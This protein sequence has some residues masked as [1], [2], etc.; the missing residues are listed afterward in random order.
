MSSANSMNCAGDRMPCSGWSQRT[1]ASAPTMRWSASRDQR[2]EVDLDL[3]ALHGVVERGVEV[4]PADG[5]AAHPV[6]V[7]ER[8]LAAPA[9]LLGPVHGHVRI[10]QEVVT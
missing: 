4:E 3:T 2:L 7:E 6:H 1:R 8:H 5:A 9:P 10:V